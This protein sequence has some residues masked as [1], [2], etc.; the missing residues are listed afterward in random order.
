M[1]QE[2][3]LRRLLSALSLPISG[4]MTARF[5]LRLRKRERGIVRMPAEEDTSRLEFASR[6]S[7]R[8]TPGMSTVVAEFGEDP[9]RQRR[10]IALV[11]SGTSDSRR[12]LVRPY[13][14][15]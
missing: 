13:E 14:S 7:F 1:R 11:Q 12:K 15:H 3:V 9:V 2:G 6:P 4:I 10:E 8:S 5:L